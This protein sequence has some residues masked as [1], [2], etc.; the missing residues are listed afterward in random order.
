M[1]TKVKPIIGRIGGKARLAPWVIEQLKRFEWSIYCE[2]FA[3]SAAVYFRMINEG[4]FEQI[5]ARGHHPRIVL[6]DADSRIV[7]LF[8]TCRDSPEL[9]A[10]AV[11]MT[12]YSREEHKLAQSGLG[13]IEDEIE[14]ARRY[15][16]DGWQQIGTGQRKGAWG[17]TKDEPEYKN[18]TQQ[19][20]NLPSRILAALPHLQGEPTP[21]DSFACLNK[22]GRQ[23]VDPPVD[24]RVEMARRYLV[25]DWGG[26]NKGGGQSW[27]AFTSAM[28][29]GG[30]HI[31]VPREWNTIPTRI[32]N[33]TNH[34]KKCYIENDDA[35]KCME[36]WA[37]PHTCFYLDPPYINAEKYYAH[38]AK[39]SDA[40]NLDLHHRVA[41]IANEIEAAAVVVS[42][43]PNDLLDELYPEDRWERHYKETVASSAGIIRQSKTRKRPKRTELLL[44][45]KQKGKVNA[46]LSGQLNLFA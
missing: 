1:A 10:Y 45:R 41:A 39:Q 35:V 34:L 33:A 12:P 2:P 36:R 37:T 42:Y 32:L 29:S 21:V 25:D 17:Y 26:F 28:Q 5:R 23:F 15:L 9:L 3:G 40:D 44:V 18:L 22:T 38:N 16:V 31:D 14:Q 11:A 4:I 13:E 46:N 8:R 24:V 30:N 27:R 43:Y 20:H 7:Q 19:W 6:N